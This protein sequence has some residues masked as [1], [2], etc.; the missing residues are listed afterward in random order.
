MVWTGRHPAL[1]CPP[2]CG[3]LGPASPSLAQLPS[4]PAWRTGTRRAPYRQVPRGLLSTGEGPGLSSRRLRIPS[5][6][7]PRLA[8][9]P[10]GR[11][12]GPRLAPGAALA[13]WRGQDV[14]PACLPAAPDP[15]G[16]AGTLAGP[17]TQ[18]RPGWSRG[19]PVSGDPHHLRGTLLCPSSPEWPWT[20]GR[21]APPWQWGVSRPTLPLRSS[22]GT[23]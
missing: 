13:T 15:P 5:R 2:T 22:R 23:D 3:H 20:K 6:W 7:Q 17:N 4:P 11:C 18:P 8:C 14:V 1:P 21:Q 19:C 12:C 9:L 16:K 10:G